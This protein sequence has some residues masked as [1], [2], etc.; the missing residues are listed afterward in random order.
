MWYGDWQCVVCGM[1]TVAMCGVTGGVWYGDWQ[2]VASLV[3]C[4]V[5]TVARCGM[6]TMA[7]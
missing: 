1:V 6:V 7:M 4:G 5:V 3:V 2:C